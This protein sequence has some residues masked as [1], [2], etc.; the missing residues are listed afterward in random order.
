MQLV[1]LDCECLKSP[2]SM[3]DCCIKV[4]N[5]MVTAP[6]EYLDLLAISIGNMFI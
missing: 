1:L 4:I 5:T 3:Y 6:S 2:L